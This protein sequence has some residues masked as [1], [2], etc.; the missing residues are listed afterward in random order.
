MARITEARAVG[1]TEIAR[2]PAGGP[3]HRDSPLRRRSSR[4]CPGQVRRCAGA[5]GRPR[6]SPEPGRASSTSLPTQ[7]P[8]SARCVGPLQRRRSAGSSPVRM[9]TKALV[10][11]YPFRTGSSSPIRMPADVNPKD[12]SASAGCRGDGAAERTAGPPW[13]RCRHPARRHDCSQGME[14]SRSDHRR[15]CSRGQEMTPDF[16][17]ARPHSFDRIAAADAFGGRG[18]VR[19]G[20]HPNDTGASSGPG[21]PC[22]C[23]GDGRQGTGAAHDAGRVLRNGCGLGSGWRSGGSECFA[24]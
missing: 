3:R 14:S 17:P 8:R 7:N 5:V 16:A 9:G 12:K 1:F 23:D 11:G 19:C 22:T 24:G 20:C 13:S 21:E 15:R 4:W 18:R 10:R 2:L 6:F